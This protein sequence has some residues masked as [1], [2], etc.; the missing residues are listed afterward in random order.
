MLTL[1]CNIKTERRLENSYK[2]TKLVSQKTCLKYI[3][4]L[5]KESLS[6]LT[7]VKNR[8]NCSRIP[9]KM[10]FRRWILDT[11]MIRWNAFAEH[12]SDAFSG[13]YRAFADKIISNDQYELIHVFHQFPLSVNR[14]AGSLQT[15][16]LWK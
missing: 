8:E 12:F 7:Y 10:L 1:I 16:K 13:N 14:L 15:I 5:K 9:N 2:R 3:K 4:D 6:V 11:L